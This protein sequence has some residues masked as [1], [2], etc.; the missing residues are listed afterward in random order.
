MAAGGCSNITKGFAAAVELG[1]SPVTQNKSVS[2]TNLPPGCSVTATAGGY[3]INFNTDAKPQAQ[4]GAP[5]A[6]ASGP[7][8]D[9]T[10]DLSGQ[11]MD[12]KSKG[13]FVVTPTANKPNTFTFTQQ[14]KF[15]ASVVVKGPSAGNP[16]GTVMGTWGKS[17]IPAQLMNF[18]A[19]GSPACTEMKWGNGADFV[20]M[21]YVFSFVLSIT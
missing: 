4:C 21:P 3:E 11:W 2:N 8:I 20:K 17:Q 13:I 18:S 15:A 19:A 10:C 16:Q 5:A 14:Q 1:L 6:G 9:Y 7:P 12:I